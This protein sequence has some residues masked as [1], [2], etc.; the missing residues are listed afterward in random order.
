MEQGHNWY[1]E[2]LLSPGESVNL[3]VREKR[4]FLSQPNIILP[5]APMIEPTY[6]FELTLE[7]KK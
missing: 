5:L 4:L 1:A 3:I 6:Y 2:Y 7:P